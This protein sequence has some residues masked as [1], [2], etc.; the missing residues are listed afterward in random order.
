MQAERRLDRSH[1][2]LG[3]GLTL[4]RRLVEMHGGSVSAHSDGPG[5]GSEF[6]VRLP[7]LVEERQEEWLRRPPDHEQPP[8]P[9]ACCRILVVDDNV[10]A[11]ESLAL[12]LSLENHEARTAHDG[13]SALAAAQADPPEMVILDLGM[14]G[15]TASRS[16]DGCGRCRGQRT[17]CWWH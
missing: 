7:T 3:I 4:V 5:K 16:H 11:A 17:C 8:S 12:L 13:P 2:G 6:V 10:D 15:W 14:P 9:S 1:G